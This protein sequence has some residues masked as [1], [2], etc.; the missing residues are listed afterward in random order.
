MEAGERKD[1]EKKRK[2]KRKLENKIRMMGRKEK[3][4]KYL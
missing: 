3:K 1:N 4:K 2:Y